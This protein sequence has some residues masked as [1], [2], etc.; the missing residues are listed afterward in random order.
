MWNWEQQ[1]YAGQLFANAVL[2]ATGT[3]Y[4]VGTSPEI[5]YS[6]YGTSKD[7]AAIN[8]IDLAYTIELPGGGTAGFDIE[9]ERIDEVVKETFIGLHAMLHYVVDYYYHGNHTSNEV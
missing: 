2:N 7:Y 1:R 5:L 4:R 8:D 6:S 9:V 3:I